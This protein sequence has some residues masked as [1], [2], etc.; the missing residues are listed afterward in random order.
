MSP[1]AAS[2]REAAAQLRYRCRE[3]ALTRT[4]GATP[5]SRTPTRPT[6]PITRSPGKSRVQVTPAPGAPL[7]WD[8]PAAGRAASGP[9]AHRQPAGALGGGC[10]FPCASGDFGAQDGEQ[11]GRA[12]RRRREQIDDGQGGAHGGIDHRRGPVQAARGARSL[13]DRG[14]GG[15]GLPTVGG[16]AFGAGVAAA[17]GVGRRGRLVP[18]AHGIRTPGEV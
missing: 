3:L 10:F 18:A 1:R 13:L 17:G 5:V 2:T 12:Q 16:S 11:G 9:L 7:R 6:T 8:R 14:R 4:R 15:L